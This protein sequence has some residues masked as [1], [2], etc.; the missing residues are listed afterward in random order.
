MA[1]RGGSGY[2]CLVSDAPYALALIE[3]QAPIRET[4]HEYLSAQP[5]FVCEVVAG[6]VEEFLAARPGVAR[7]PQLV[8]S[9]IGLP[10]LSGSEGLPLIQA[11]LPGA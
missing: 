1:P 9:D 4:L 7:P 2:P 5:E 8:L 6:S 3:D 11:R 10:G